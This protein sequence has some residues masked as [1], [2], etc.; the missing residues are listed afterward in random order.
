MNA[1]ENRDLRYAYIALLFGD[2]KL[3]YWTDEGLKELAK[4][5]AEMMLSN[6]WQS[7]YNALKKKRTLGRPEYDS[8]GI[9][10]DDVVNVALRIDFRPNWIGLMYVD[11]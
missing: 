8:D 10:Y 9:W 5:S 1:I 11:G 7:Y 4:E 3:K 2:S 6:N